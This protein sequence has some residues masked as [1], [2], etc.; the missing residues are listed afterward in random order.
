MPSVTKISRVDAA[1]ASVADGDGM[2][3]VAAQKQPLQQGQ[4]FASRTAQHRSFPIGAILFQAL[5]IF[6]ELFPADVSL[7]MLFQLDAPVGHC[8]RTHFFLN[9]ARRAD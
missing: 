7:M 8:N 4:A 5:A 1:V 9:L 2:A 3:T 6:Q